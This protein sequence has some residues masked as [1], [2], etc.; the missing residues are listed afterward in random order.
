M[1]LPKNVNYKLKYRP[2]YAAHLGKYKWGLPMT[3][4]PA[5][6]WTDDWD[7]RCR[8]IYAHMMAIKRGVVPDQDRRGL[9]HHAAP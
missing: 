8:L 2:N 7:K 1:P 4:N 5:G 6:S 3:G 9:W